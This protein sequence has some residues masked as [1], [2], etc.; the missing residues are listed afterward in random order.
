M[1]GHLHL[2]VLVRFTGCW[3]EILW[4]SWVL[5]KCGGGGEVVA[6]RL[7]CSESFVRQLLMAT[8]DRKE[9]GEFVVDKGR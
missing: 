1:G 7:G 2:D 9:I 3:R 6:L 5:V 8:S 4:E